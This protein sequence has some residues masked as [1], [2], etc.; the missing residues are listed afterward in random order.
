MLLS[1]VSVRF[2]V[3]SRKSDGD[4]NRTEPNDNNIN[5]NN[6]NNNNNNDNVNSIN[7]RSAA[8]ATSEY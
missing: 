8:R 2:V 3:L 4:K 1:F 5:N 7:S 6:M